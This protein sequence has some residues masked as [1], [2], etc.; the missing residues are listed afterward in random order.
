MILVSKC[1][2]GYT[3]QQEE[4]SRYRS[5]KM[6]ARVRKGRIGIRSARGIEWYRSRSIRIPVALSSQ[7]FEG[8]CPWNSSTKVWITIQPV[9][10]QHRDRV[11]WDPPVEANR[12]V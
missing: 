3:G 4:K 9:V 6:S 2:H 5:R 8:T 12:M 1:A 10:G 11:R 7:Q